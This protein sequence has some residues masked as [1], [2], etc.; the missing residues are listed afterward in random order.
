MGISLDASSPCFWVC[1]RPVRRRISIDRRE[2]PGGL[3]LG[4]ILDFIFLCIVVKLASVRLW[5]EI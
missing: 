4:G 2:R 1:S 5:W 3:V